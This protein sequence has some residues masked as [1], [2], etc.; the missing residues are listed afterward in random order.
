MAQ[1]PAPASMAH[2]HSL[3]ARAAGRDSPTGE[4]AVDMSGVSLPALTPSYAP[5]GH[6]VLHAGVHTVDAT[7][8]LQS[9][10]SALSAVQGVVSSIQPS[11]R[12]SAKE[13]AGMEGVDIASDPWCPAA[14]PPALHLS[15]TRVHAGLSVGPTST[16]AYGDGGA[17]VDVV[18][19]GL[20]LAVVPGRGGH[21]KAAVAWPFVT[22][23]P[24]SL[25]P[26]GAQAAGLTAVRV[27][28]R[29]KDLPF[30]VASLVAHHASLGLV[31][32][33]S[34]LSRRKR[35]RWGGVG[36]YREGTWVPD[37]MVLA[38]NAARSH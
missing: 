20:R 28:C 23:E 21:T 17:S 15:L 3:L 18:L 37:G 2:Y 35:H 11:V 6:V 27:S 14:D 31:K 7:V 32:A 24:G 13:G 38:Y 4:R 12:S 33:S 30:S 22:L 16:P 10:H 26:G 29:C 9:L 8:S 34:R 5:M 1:G 36:A 19:G 25:G